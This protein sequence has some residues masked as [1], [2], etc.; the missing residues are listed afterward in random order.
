MCTV[1]HGQPVISASQAHHEGIECSLPCFRREALIP[2]VMSPWRPGVHRSTRLRQEVI[3]LGG[4]Q[5][6][7]KLEQQVL[8]APIYCMCTAI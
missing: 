5:F 1:D 7:M 8:N 3:V 2:D 4:K 6:A